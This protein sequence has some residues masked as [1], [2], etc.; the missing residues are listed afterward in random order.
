MKLK[1]EFR[2]FG[3]PG[4]GKTTYLTKQIQ[5]AFNEV[6]MN[7]VLVASFSKSAVQE[8]ISRNLSVKERKLIRKQKNFG[9][10][11]SIA[12]SLLS[13]EI[14]VVETPEYIEIFNKKNPELSISL[15][16]VQSDVLDET[17]SYSPK[18]KEINYLMK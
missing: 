15:N 16:N 1:R 17:P 5:R 3:P 10:L 12:Y 2:V 18:R 4:T 14:K 7:K 8:L 13:K 9:T 11:H 6:G